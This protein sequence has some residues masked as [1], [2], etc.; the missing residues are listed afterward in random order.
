MSL[1]VDST[2]GAPGAGL[3]LIR[4]L[5]NPVA[6]GN[7]QDAIPGYPGYRYPGTPGYPDTR[8]A[9]LAPGSSSGTTS[10]RI[11]N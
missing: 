6:L 8:L 7:F 1:P 2:C 9:A 11:E 3:P 5:T 10:T 4:A